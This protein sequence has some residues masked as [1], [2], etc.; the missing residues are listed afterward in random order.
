MILAAIVSIMTTMFSLYTTMQIVYTFI[1]LHLPTHLLYL[2]G[3][4]Y[5]SKF[6]LQEVTKLSRWLSVEPRTM[7]DQTN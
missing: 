7:I 4:A 5:D 3:R 6:Q 2:G 1:I